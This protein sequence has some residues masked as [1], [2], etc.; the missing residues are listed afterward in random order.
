MFYTAEL[1]PIEVLHC[2]NNDVRL[3]CSSDLDLDQ[4]TFIYE[5][6][7]YLVEI[8]RMSENELTTKAF[9][10]IVLQTYIQIC[11]HTYTPTT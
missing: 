10:V 5:L 8:Y 2:G 7:P 6:D 3:F 1:M 4:M 11:R 9:E